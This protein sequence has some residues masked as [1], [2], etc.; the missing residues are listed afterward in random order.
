MSTNIKNQETPLLSSF[1]RI[2]KKGLRSIHIERD[3]NNLEVAKGYVL[4][5]Q[6]RAS[7]DRIVNGLNGQS[8][9]RSWTI[10]GPYG[11]GKSGSQVHFGDAASKGERGLG[12]EAF[13]RHRGI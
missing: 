12:G 5:S 8:S 13:L 2:N 4:T 7:L 9:N 3:L 1:V 6:A 11:S 10:T